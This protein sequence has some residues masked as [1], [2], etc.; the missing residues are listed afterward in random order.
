M[1]QI[2]D[3]GDREVKDYAEAQTIL[4]NYLKSG[5]YY[6]LPVEVQDAMSQFIHRCRTY[7]E[8]SVDGQRYE[9][10]IVSLEKP[11]YIKFSFKYD[12]KNKD[13]TFHAEYN[14]EKKY[15]EN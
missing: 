7:V 5:L 14:K 2:I 13:F 12:H 1:L 15:K 8:C 3:F 6:Y 11:Y 10:H 9:R 4:L